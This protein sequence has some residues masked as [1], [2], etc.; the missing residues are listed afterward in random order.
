FINREYISNAGD[1]V[2]IYRRLAVV[3]EAREVK[4]LREEMTDRFGKITEPVENLLQV[5][6]IRIA[7]KNLGVV[8][9]KEK[10]LRVEIVFSDVK[11]ISAQGVIELSRI[12]RRDF[13]FIEDSRRIF[14]TFKTKKNLLSRILNVL[15]SLTPR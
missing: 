10:N 4:D 3:H 7:A 15:K 9:V 12:F 2:E 14:I 5:A 6:L 13:K 1:K 11:K 8:S